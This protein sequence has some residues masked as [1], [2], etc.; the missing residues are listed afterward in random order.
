V[1]ANLASCLHFCTELFKT[2][3]T[4]SYYYVCGFMLLLIRYSMSTRTIIYGAEWKLKAE[5]MSQATKALFIWL[6]ASIQFSFFSFLLFTVEK[7]KSTKKKKTF[8]SIFFYKHRF[9]IEFL[10]FFSMFWKKTR[11]RGSSI[12]T[13][14]N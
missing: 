11:N 2:L 10:I 6:K 5:I 9:Y 8:K 13:G 14:K 4:L 1:K 3:F 7:K 12:K